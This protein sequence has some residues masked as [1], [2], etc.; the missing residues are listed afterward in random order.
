MELF[1]NKTGL[2]I[3]IAIASTSIKGICMTGISIKGI[4]DKDARG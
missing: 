4:S 2:A 3:A 1:G